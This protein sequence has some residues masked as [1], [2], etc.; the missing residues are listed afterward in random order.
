MKRVLL[1]LAV[2]IAVPTQAQAREWV[3]QGALPGLA[4]AFEQRAG[5]STIVE[6][7]PPGETVERWTR[8]ATN[9]RFAGLMSGATLANWRDNFAN[10]LR[11]GCPGATMSERQLT[12]SGRPALELRVDCPLNPATRLPETFFLRAIA[13]R[14][15]L[16]VAQIAFR[17]RPSAA[18]VTYA[19]THLATV[20]YCE[21]AGAS[22]ACLA[23]A[24]TP[25]AR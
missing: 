15:D 19:Q 20:A 13:G 21:T 3:A 4:V 2:L 22:R 24:N 16:H 14:S 6:R 9:Q 25:E 12:V 5:G 8:M 23:A 11:G 18:E 17:H 7:I 10:Q 1:A